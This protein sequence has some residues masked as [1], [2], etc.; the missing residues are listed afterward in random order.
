[1]NSAYRTKPLRDQDPPVCTFTLI[2]LLVVISI[3]SL[4]I[5]I[6]LPALSNARK[7]A[8]LS[9]CAS[10]IRQNGLALNMYAMDYKRHLPTVFVGGG[11][12]WAN[13]IVWANWSRPGPGSY[14][15]LGLLV[16]KGYLQGHASLYCPSQKEATYMANN[17]PNWPDDQ[18][19]DNSTTNASY[20]MMRWWSST[21]GWHTPV[22]D[23][24][25][26]GA[27]LHD[28]I[29]TIQPAGSRAHDD[30]WN[31]LYSDGHVKVFGDTAYMNEAT[32]L[33]GKSFTYLIEGSYNDSHPNADSMRKR[34]T[35]NF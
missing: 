25:E 19:A 29:S 1:M 30:K 3:I 22:M 10:N 7:A 20:N 28:L 23:D 35:L 9:A 6:L 31:V 5:S 33:T 14:K 11:Q 12:P 27:I 16:N 8:Q 4:L 18:E 17:Y 21:K 13:I 32:S 34:F 26:K 2:E 24:Y 15:S